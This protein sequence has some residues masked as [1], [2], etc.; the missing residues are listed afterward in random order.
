MAWTRTHHDSLCTDVR[1]STSTAL[2]TLAA[3]FASLSCRLTSIDWRCTDLA[4]VAVLGSTDRSKARVKVNTD[5]WWVSPVIHSRESATMLDRL[6]SYE[7]EWT[8]PNEHGG[9]AMKKSNSTKEHCAGSGVHK[10]HAPSIRLSSATNSVWRCNVCD[11]VITR[12]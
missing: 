8:Q 1:Q 9:T 7:R 12:S 5:V 3:A 6:S 2:A 11:D 4:L 10:T